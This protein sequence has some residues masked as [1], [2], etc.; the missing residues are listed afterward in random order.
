[1]DI[2]NTLHTNESFIEVLRE[3]F[4]SHT[5]VSLLFDDN[6]I[7]RT[8]G[9][10]KMFSQ[11]PPATIELDNGLKIEAAKIVAINGLFLSDYSEC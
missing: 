5:K 9:L 2:R 7:V 6:G 3:S 11:G 4:H 8:E 10:I 1:M